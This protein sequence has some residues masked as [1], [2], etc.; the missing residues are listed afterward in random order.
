MMNCLGDTKHW[1]ENTCWIFDSDFEFLRDDSV[2]QLV[3]TGSRCLD[4]K[5]RLLLAGVPED[6]IFVEPDEF[7][8]AEVLHYTP[9]D[10]IYLLS[11]TDSMALSY[12]IYDKMKSLAL[13][14]KEATR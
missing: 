10:D 1:S 11:G 8:A 12:Q 4:Y 9:G 14:Q 13:S 3:C 5:L 2:V 6:R 7:K